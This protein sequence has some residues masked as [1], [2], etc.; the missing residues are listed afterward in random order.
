MSREDFRRNMFIPLCK[1]VR[2]EL[3]RRFK[4]PENEAVYKGVLA[5][6]PGS[7]RF[8]NEEDLIGIFCHYYPDESVSSRALKLEVALL[9]DVLQRGGED[10]PEDLRSFY[11]FLLP[12]E[13]VL[14][15]MV[16]LLRIA[17]SLPISSA[18]SERSFSTMRRIM[19]YLR[20][21][22][23]DARLSNLGVLNIARERLESLNLDDVIDLFAESNRRM[24]LK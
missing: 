5:M 20:N 13:R 22:T 17:L 2:W 14:P 24:L 7:P 11:S 3:F 15:N 23:G 12:Q 16:G 9:R 10:L 19:D 1:S 4:A 21:S 6:I 8:L 18:S